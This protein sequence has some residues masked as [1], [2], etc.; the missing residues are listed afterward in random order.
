MCQSSWVAHGQALGWYGTIAG[1]NRDQNKETSCRKGESRCSQLRHH[2]T[3]LCVVHAGNRSTQIGTDNPKG[4][5]NLDLHSKTL[6]QTH[7]H[8]H[9]CKLRHTQTHAH[10][11]TYTHAHTGHTCTYTCINRHR[12]TRVYTH[13]HA[14]HRHT[15]THIHTDK[16]AHFRRNRISGWNSDSF[17]NLHEECAEQPFGRWGV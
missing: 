15:C 7:T 8:R 6:S 17:R 14:T 1:P 2:S 11:D 3:H 4:K 9:T 10:S 16:T 5:T 13:A 12:E